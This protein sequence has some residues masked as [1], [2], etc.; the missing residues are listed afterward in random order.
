MEIWETLERKLSGTATAHA[1][2]ALACKFHDT[3]PKYGEPFEDFFAK[4]ID[5]RNR[6]RGTSDE[7]T[8]SHFKV[9]ILSSMPPWWPSF[10]IRN[11]RCHLMS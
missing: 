2:F 6:L 3:L 8:D 5:I 11:Q 9:H 4:L 1:Q 7:I 10:A